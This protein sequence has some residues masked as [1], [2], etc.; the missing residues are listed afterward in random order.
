MLKKRIKVMNEVKS[1]NVWYKGKGYWNEF[2]GVYVKNK[3][4][5]ILKESTIKIYDFNFYSIDDIKKD[6]E[7]KYWE[8]ISMFLTKVYDSSFEGYNLSDLKNVY[9]DS[10]RLRIY[11]GNDYNSILDKLIELKII[12]IELKINKHNRKQ[13]CK[14]IS[15]N[16]GFRS[17]N[18]SNF[19]ER[20]LINASY[21]KSILKYYSKIS[22]NR[23]PLEKYIEKVLDKCSFDLKDK[24]VERNN[25]IAEEKFNE[26]QLRFESPFESEAEKKKLKKKLS[27]KDLFLKNYLEILNNFYSIFF[28]KLNCQSL[29]RSFYYNIKV[30]SYSNRISHIVSNMPKRYRKDLL[31]DGEKIVEVDIISSQ[32]A[33]LT[34]LLDKWINS[35]NKLPDININPYM[36]IDRLKMIYNEKSRIDLYKYMA[37]KLYGIKAVGNSEI[38]SEMKSVFMGLLFGKLIN[39]KYKGREKKEL[40]NEVFG[41]DFYDLLVHISNLDVEGIEEKKYRNLNALLNREES[42]FLKEVMEVLMKQNISF[43]PLY[44]CL[45]VKIS[46]AGKVNS[47]FQSIIEKNGFKGKVKVK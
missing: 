43:L 4:N 38:R 42:K 7:Y 31:M 23:N 26:E 29:E 36:A 16:E 30:S 18:G 41:S 2:K 14:Y 19:V 45:I 15:L 13:Y 11:L 9:M 32:A 35:I 21:E 28:K 22:N 5:E 24:L 44:D 33:F 39:P 27:N 17:E 25:Q 20:N 8:K 46:D 1:H 34:I 47:T 37:L 40:I 6:F 3:A 10:D 12:E